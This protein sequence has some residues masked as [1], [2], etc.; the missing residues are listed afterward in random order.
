[1]MKCLE[2]R[3]PPLNFV[4]NLRYRLVASEGGALLRHEASLLEEIEWI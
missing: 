1:M 4:R 2:D 3:R